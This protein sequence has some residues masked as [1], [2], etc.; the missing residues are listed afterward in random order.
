MARIQ[1]EQGADKLGVVVLDIDPSETLD[2]VRRW[3]RELGD[4]PYPFALDTGSRVTLAYGVRSTDT[5][6][7]IDRTGKLIE[8][9]DGRPQSEEQLREMVGKLV[10][11]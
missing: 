11:T 6:M 2:D 1:A 8:R 3:K 7:F 9:V 4:P 5:K 10:G